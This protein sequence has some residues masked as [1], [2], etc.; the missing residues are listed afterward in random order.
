MRPHASVPKQESIAVKGK[1]GS[2]PQPSTPRWPINETLGEVPPRCALWLADKLGYGDSLHGLGHYYLNVLPMLTDR[3]HVIPIV[4]RSSQRLA[5]TFQLNGIAL[6][7]L[8]HRRFDPRTLWTLI[9]LIRTERVDVLQLHGHGSS[10]MGRLAG[11]LTHTPVVVRQGDSVPAPWYIRLSDWLLS[12]FTARAIAVS[13]SVKMFC[14]RGRSLSA[15]RI[16]VLPNGVKPVVGPTP[17]EL[18]QWRQALRLPDRAKL[19]G[20]VTR[21]HPIKGVGYLI[22]AM[23]QVLR[24]VPEAHLVLWGDGPQQAS[25]EARARMLGV[26]DR[27]RFDGYRSDVGRRLALLDCFVLPSISEGSPNALLEALMASRPI[28]ATQVGGVSELVRADEEAVLVAPQDAPALAG[29][30]IRVLTDDTLAQRLSRAAQAA[31]RRYTMER[32][33]VE[34][35]RLYAEV[36]H[37][38]TRRVAQR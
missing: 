20:S 1:T 21:F 32:H 7:V 6:R 17:E 28:V 24:A 30:I 33:V 23:P 3:M 18:A 13:E 12:Q 16:T 11:W 9:Q 34:L 29:A 5:D 38:A 27:I 25:L 8:H 22:E 15:A 31:S 4:C 2:G 37:D 14:V 19:I 36:V 35:C 10:T 26:A